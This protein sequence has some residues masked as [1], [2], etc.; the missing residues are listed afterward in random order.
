MANPGPASVQTANYVSPAPNAYRLVAYGKSVPV[1]VAGDVP[2]QII[3]A[4]NFVPAI[5]VTC[6]SSGTTANIA[7]AT[8]GVYTLPAQ[9]GTTV[10]ATAAL[11][12]QTTAT[13]AYVRA[14]SVAN[15][16]ISAPQ[17]YANIGT[18]VANGITDIYVYGYDVQP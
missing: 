11:T 13:F 10:H 17:L 12:G 16:M 14:A 9:G 8:V 5:V 4:G 15:A 18:T 1:S 2:L 7:A 3:T 6:N